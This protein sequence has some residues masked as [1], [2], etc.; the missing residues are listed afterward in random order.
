ML[1]LSTFHRFEP[2]GLLIPY[3]WAA[4]GPTRWEQQF[5]QGSSACKRF[6]K[7]LLCASVAVWKVLYELNILTQKLLEFFRNWKV[8]VISSLDPWRERIF[9]DTNQFPDQTKIVNS[10]K[11]ICWIWTKYDMSKLIKPRAKKTEEPD[12]ICPALRRYISCSM[13]EYMIFRKIKNYCGIIYMTMYDVY[14]EHWAG[15]L[16][17]PQPP[18]AQTW[19][20]TFVDG[21]APDLSNTNF[22][23][24]VEVI[25]ISIYQNNH[26]PN[27]YDIYKYLRHKIS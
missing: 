11:P 10:L 2:N 1:F 16:V 14:D 26:C 22:V 6:N 12:A 17:S 19:Q 7:P 27:I 8:L 23:L 15:N 5:P 9:Q 20:S 24:S 3:L 21:S 25:I 4:G 18:S 13:S